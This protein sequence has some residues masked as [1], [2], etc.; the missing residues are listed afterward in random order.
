[1]TDKMVR[2]RNILLLALILE[3]VFMAGL[4]VVFYFTVLLFLTIYCFIKNIICIGVIL[5][6]SSLLDKEQIKIGDILDKDSQNVF[7]FGGLGLI[8]YDNQRNIIWVSDLLQEL[9]IHI[10]GRKLLEWEPLLS[11]LFEDDGVHTI[12][13]QSRKYEVY[14]NRD[15]QMLYLKDVTDLV[16]LSKDYEDERV[17]IMY[18]TIDNYEDIIDQADESKNASIQSKTKQVILD[19]AK[20]NGIIIRQ[21]KTAGFIAICNDRVFHKQVEQKFNIL[22]TFKLVAD[23]LGEVM[24]L[25]IGIGRGSTILRELDELA[26]LALSLSHSRGGDQVTIKAHDEPTR[27]FGGNSENF[28]KNNKIRARVISQ[29]LVGLLKTADQILIMGHRQTDF[30]SIGASIGMR[31]ICQA[32]HKD[33]RIIIDPDSLD[34]KAREMVLEIN[35]SLE[36]AL[37]SPEQAEEIVHKDTLLIIVD[38]HKPSLSIT[39]ALYN[40]VQNVIVID[41]HRRGEEFID[42]PVLTYLEP[43]ASSTVELVVELIEYQ[44]MEV[45]LSQMEATIMYTGMLIDTNYFKTR[46]GVRTFQA[47]ASLREKQ[48]DVTKAYSYLEDDYQTM[49]QTL[50]IKQNTYLFGQDILIGYGSENTFYNATILA[51]TCNELLNIHNMKAAFVVCRKSKTEIAISARSKKDINVQVIMEKMGGGGHYTMAACQIQEESLVVVINQLEETI[52]E[53][54]DERTNIT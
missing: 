18:I 52:N 11:P 49:Q 25:S 14:N 54:L 26:Y 31:A 13:I 9:N 41:H 7:I 53:Y 24:T 19:W 50:S 17:C 6:V 21:Y 27:F 36:D 12:D 34:D 30:D 35:D 10:V 32:H 46:V 37:L 45:A 2:R 1:M 38:H 43:S 33:A 8:R 42:R 3:F 5:Y 23:E 4:Y 51:K 47:A 39:E 28:E 29:S 40:K 44:K 15:T 20:E 16:S 22:D 48:A